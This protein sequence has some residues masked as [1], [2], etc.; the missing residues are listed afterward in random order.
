[1]L[2]KPNKGFV[3]EE[4]TSVLCQVCYLLGYYAFKLKKLVV[5][6]DSQSIL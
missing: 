5:C 2:S 4:D 3:F 6:H 1:M